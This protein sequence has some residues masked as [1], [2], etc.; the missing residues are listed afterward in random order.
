MIRR[1]IRTLTLCTLFLDTAYAGHI[2]ETVPKVEQ[3]GGMDVRILGKILG[4]LV[5]KKDKKRESDDPMVVAQQAINNSEGAIQRLR[6]QLPQNLHPSQKPI[7]IEQL[8]S[9]A[10]D[11]ID[12]LNLINEEIVQQGGTPVQDPGSYTHRNGPLDQRSGQFTTQGRSFDGRANQL[13]FDHDRRGPPMQ[14][15]GQRQG[16]PSAT[17]QPERADAKRGGYS[18]R[19]QENPYGAQ[20]A[21]PDAPYSQQRGTNIPRNFQGDYRSPPAPTAQSRSFDQSPGGYNRQGSNESM[22]GVERRPYDARG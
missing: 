18:D 4:K 15:G 13:P 17:Y 1:T 3:E 11:V 22:Q 10:K 20:G 16:Q 2:P 6:I 7:I 9:L 14:Y 8:Q 19:S 21:N 12:N 5:D